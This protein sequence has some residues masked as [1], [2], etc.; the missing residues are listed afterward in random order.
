MYSVA[1]RCVDCFQEA[2]IILYLAAYTYVYHMHISHVST[3]YNYVHVQCTMYM[4]ATNLGMCMCEGA[5]R[6][7][8][9]HP[10]C[11]GLVLQYFI[12]IRTKICFAPQVYGAI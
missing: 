8:F 4:Y 11:R 3:H 7:V 9:T 1:S 5:R 2:C 10:L 12:A 6:W